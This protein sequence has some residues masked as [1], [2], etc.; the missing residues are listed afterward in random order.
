M[1]YKHANRATTSYVLCSFFWVIPRRLNFTCRPFGTLYV[2]HLH[3]L[4]K[5]EEFSSRLYRLWRWNR[6]SVPKVRHIK[7]RRRG[8]TQ[9][10]GYN[11]Q[12]MAKVWNQAAFV[13]GCR[14]EPGADRGRHRRA[15]LGQEESQCVFL[16]K[17]GQLLLHLSPKLSVMSGKAVITPYS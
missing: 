13:A 8:I 6:Q 1:I 2:F 4:C 10:I 11:V 3:R 17:H 16:Q 9:N 5:Q 12:N 14:A 15:A 7:F